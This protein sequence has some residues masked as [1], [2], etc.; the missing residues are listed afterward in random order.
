MRDK[1]PILN[2]LPS[3]TRVASS[4]FVSQTPRFKLAAVIATLTVA[5]GSS[6]DGTTDEPSAGIPAS[7]TTR[8]D[9]GVE[10]WSLEIGDAG[11][12]IEGHDPSGRVVVRIQARESIAADGKHNSM[13]LERIGS[14]TFAIEAVTS[15]DGRKL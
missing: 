14:S 10:Q 7:T 4:W 12:T 15:L 2:G 8:C 13:A 9:L 1:P 5:C 11:S 6:P 3:G